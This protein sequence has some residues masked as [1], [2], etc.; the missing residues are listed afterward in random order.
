MKIFTFWEGPMPDY[1]KLCLKTWKHPF[2]MLNYDN[3]PEYTSID[4]ERLKRFTLPQIA[5]CV[6]VHVLRDQGGRWLD[7]DTIMLSD[8]LPDTNMVGDPVARTNTI[9][10]LYTEPKTDMYIK[11]ADYQ[12][13]I[14]A[15]PETPTHW[16]I[17]GNA[18]TDDYVKAY[19]DI[20]ISPVRDHW[21]EI[22][23][24][25]GDAPRRDKYTKFYFSSHY[26]LS[27]I[28]QT[29]M[30]MLHNSWTPEWYK[31]LKSSDLLAINYTMSNIL[32]EALDQ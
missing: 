18:F 32:R 14:I 1:I 3:L 20:T 15:S 5:D 2:I 10:Y 30:I 19:K 17:M 21:P 24:I 25:E 29:N 13:N 23:L 26:H 11:W 31:A 8:D 12:D 22:Y 9:G 4:L 7:A 6:R 16:A 28:R 27:D